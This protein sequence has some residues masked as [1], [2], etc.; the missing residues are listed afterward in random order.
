MHESVNPPLRPRHAAGVDVL[1]ETLRI[2]S[3]LNHVLIVLFALASG[4]FKLVGGKADLEVFAHLGMNSTAVAL[5]G[6]A[7]A[8]G[9]LGLVFATTTR[10]AAFVVAA[11]NAL[12]TAGLFAAGV[13]PFGWI[14][15]V[16]I[17]MSLGEL[18]MAGRAGIF[19]VP[20]RKLPAETSP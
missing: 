8:A 16:F 1:P 2:A 9:G 3:W 17:A 7:Q 14:S 19:V 12:A 5:F 13:Q 11:C 10:G 6:L 20:G 15:L 4:L 18:R